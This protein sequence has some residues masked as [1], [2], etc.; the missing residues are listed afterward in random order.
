MKGLY[1]C[2]YNFTATKNITDGSCCRDSRDIY[3]EDQVK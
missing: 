3:S 1:K 2:K